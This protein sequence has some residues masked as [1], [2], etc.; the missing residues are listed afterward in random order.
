VSLTLSKPTDHETPAWAASELQSSHKQDF[1]PAGRGQGPWCEVD[2]ESTLTNGG[3]NS[4]RQMEV[5]TMTLVAELIGACAVALV[6]LGIF[7]ALAVAFFVA[8]RF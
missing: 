3:W 8:S 5:I 4:D 7:L 2:R 1:S 6:F